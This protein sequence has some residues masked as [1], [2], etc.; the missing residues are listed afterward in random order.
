MSLHFRINLLITVLTVLFTAAVLN[1]VV[2]DT[3]RSIREEMEGANRVTL[4]LLS[5]VIRDAQVVS[6]EEGD[7]QDV[8]LSFLRELGR[9]R[10]HEI[11]LFDTDEGHIAHWLDGTRPAGGQRLSGRR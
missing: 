9:V 6:R 2:E 8:L 5:T 10:A 3:R 7:M 11:K 4:Q 1:I